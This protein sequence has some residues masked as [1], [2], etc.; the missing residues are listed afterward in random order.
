MFQRRH[1]NA[2]TNSA[3]ERIPEHVKII[4]NGAQNAICH[5]DFFKKSSL[6]REIRFQNYYDRTFYAIF[7]SEFPTTVIG[8]IWVFGPTLD[9]SF[10]EI[11]QDLAPDGLNQF[12]S[13]T[14]NREG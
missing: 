4:S 11:L 12:H 9:K 6:A 7:I 1:F 5:E 10:I 8:K 13:L 3:D 14:G 2:M